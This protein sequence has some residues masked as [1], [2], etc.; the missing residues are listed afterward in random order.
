MTHSPELATSSS[1]PVARRAGTLRIDSTRR[2][3]TKRRRRPELVREITLI[4]D[5][6]LSA[7]ARELA[8]RQH[9]LLTTAQVTAHGVPRSAI[10]RRCRSGRWRRPTTGVVDVGRDLPPALEPSLRARRAAVLALLAYGPTAVAVGPS[11]VALSGVWGIPAG[12]PPEVTRRDGHDRASRDGIHLRGV[13]LGETGTSP[14]GWPIEDI[15][16]ALARTLARVDPRTALGILDSAL[17]RGVIQPDDVATVRSHT[18][19]IRGIGRAKVRALEPIWDMADRRRESPLESWAYYDLVAAGL[20]PTDIQV[21]IYDARGQLIARGDIGFRRR[22]GTWLIAELQGREYHEDEP[23]VI[24]D[25][26]R[27]DDATL[28]GHTM[29]AFWALHLGAHGRMVQRMREHLER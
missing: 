1:Q 23:D 29:L 25:S 16:V 15:G 11:A 28:E 21:E 13:R 18:R 14:D 24:G 26:E 2:T 8:L 12:T 20:V 6:R 7:P 27:R 3:D 4:E 19:W 9:G 5:S 22:D 17:H 10:S